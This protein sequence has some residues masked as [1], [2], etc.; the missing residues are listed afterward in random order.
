MRHPY[1]C[2]FLAF[3]ALVAACSSV[4]EQPTVAAQPAAPS[5]PAAPKSLKSAMKGIEDDWKQ[6]EHGLA[7]ATADLPAM[8]KAAE[9]VAAV[10][11]LGYD[12]FED[13]EVPNFAQLA[14]ESEAAFLDLAKKA[15]AG[16]AAGVKA[17]AKTLQPQHCARC[18]DACEEVHG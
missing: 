13:K 1:L 3:A 18:H 12:P 17:M 7:A 16:D 15:A 14:R 9:R 4:Q 10:M 6:I 8:A 11:K 2:A 5:A